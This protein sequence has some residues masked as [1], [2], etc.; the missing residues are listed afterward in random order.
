MPVCR[1]V[2]SLRVGLC[3][4]ALLLAS[5]GCDR[6]TG[7]LR[8]WTPDD[9]GHP[10]P[11]QIDRSRVPDRSASRETSPEERRA[12]ASRTLWRVHCSTCH[13]HGGR[14]D[15]MTR[16]PGVELPDMTTAAWQDAT[17]DESMIAVITQGRG[18]MPAFGE[19]IGPEA[20]TQLVAHIRT[21]RQ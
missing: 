5:V 21:L 11:S 12:M 8:E 13:G 19:R 10:A 2:S 14:G 4:S 1:N 18:V 16:M 20:I 6:R 17:T 3:L 15:G 7:E 9:H